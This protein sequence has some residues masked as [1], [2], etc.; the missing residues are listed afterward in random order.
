M[1]QALCLTKIYVHLLVNHMNNS[2][3]SSIN[4]SHYAKYDEFYE[5]LL[6]KVKTNWQRGGNLILGLS[7][8]KVSRIFSGKQKD[9][10][11]LVKM[12][13]F[14]EIDVLFAIT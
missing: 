12:A 4:F 11:T 6:Q 13:E 8:S 3:I 10:G 14:M 9:F 7:D 2:N 5:I 1:I